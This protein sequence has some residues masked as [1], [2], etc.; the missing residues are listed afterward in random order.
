[1]TVSSLSLSPSSLLWVISTVKTDTD[2]YPSILLTF[3]KPLPPS[4]SQHSPKPKNKWIPVAAS[5]SCVIKA[6]SYE[7]KMH[8]MKASLV[9]NRTFISC[10]NP[11]EIKTNISQ[12][13]YN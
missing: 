11:Q 12:L 8:R 13:S 6:V 4:M 5:I 2:S 10:T 3:I 9:D 1:M 7:I